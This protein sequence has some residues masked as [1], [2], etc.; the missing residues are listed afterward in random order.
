[1]EKNYEKELEVD[2]R[3]LLLALKK[4]VWWIIAAGLLLG[5]IAGA[6]SQIF[7]APTYTSTSSMLVLSKEESLTS[8]ADLQL[9]TQLASDYQVFI[10]ST[11][12][13]EQVI[14]NLDLNMSAGGLKNSIS[15]ANPS[16]TRILNISVTSTNPELAKKIVDELTSV[17]SE[18]IGDK[19]EV[20]PP[21]IVEEGQM[22]T[23]K[24]GPNVKR[25]ALLGLLAGLAISAG[26]VCLFA[27]LN[28]SIKTEDD[29]ARYLGIS[30]LATIPDRKD[31]IGGKKN[32]RK[33]K[34]KK[35]REGK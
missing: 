4:K 25:N 21:K 11:P 9:G 29:I 1:M 15:I 28:D 30:T 18:Y 35:V 5:C 33:S 24:D 23:Y 6:Y 19:M 13:M 22:P 2:L 32:K 34:K 10:K 26:I 7:I 27:M 12:V 31:Y 14:E 16:G 17:S 20:I 8:M 3:E